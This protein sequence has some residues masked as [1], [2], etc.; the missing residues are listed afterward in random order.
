M[1][2]PDTFTFNVTIASKKKTADEA[3]ASVKRRSDY[4]QQVLR[5]HEIKEPLPLM[6]ITSEQGEDLIQAVMN[7]VV[8]CGDSTKSSQVR[9][10]LLEKLGSSV[11]CTMILCNTTSEWKAK[12]RYAQNVKISNYV[13]L[14]V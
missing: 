2:P 11:K 9:N 1:C 10:L 13:D 12:K 4:V 8:T 6:D 5:N 3:Q 14:V 7:I